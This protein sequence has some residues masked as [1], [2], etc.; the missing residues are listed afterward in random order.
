MIQM[1]EFL[2]CIILWLGSTLLA[3]VKKKPLPLLGLA[4]LHGAETVTVGVKTGVKYGKSKFHS[5]IMCML[6]GFTWWLP[7]KKQMKEETLTDAD[8]VRTDHDFTM[9][10]TGV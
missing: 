4:A 9:P 6:Y 1:L 3:V 2:G 5:I 7:M 8:F 10:D